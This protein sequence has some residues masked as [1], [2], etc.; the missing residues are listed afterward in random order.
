MREISCEHWVVL[1]SGKA[2]DYFAVQNMHTHTEIPHRPTRC[3]PN[4]PHATNSSLPLSFPLAFFHPIGGFAAA[5][6][7]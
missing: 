3:H 2:K 1:E 7:T 6:A 4:P 5:A